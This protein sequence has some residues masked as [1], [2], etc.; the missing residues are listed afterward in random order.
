MAGEAK[1]RSGMGVAV[2]VLRLATVVV[3]IVVLAMAWSSLAENVGQGAKR[4]MDPG[5]WLPA[6]FIIYQFMKVYFFL[7]K[8]ERAYAKGT[9]FGIERNIMGGASLLLGMFMVVRLIM[10]LSFWRESLAIGSREIF[11]WVWPVAVCLWVAAE[12]F[13]LIFLERKR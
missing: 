10:G 6:L 9:E 11:L 12:Q 13:I 5:L 4:F 7:R 3:S 1:G 2:T 8:P